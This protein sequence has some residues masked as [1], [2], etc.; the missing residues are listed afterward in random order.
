MVHWTQKYN[1]GV[2]KDYPIGLHCYDHRRQSGS[3]SVGVL[4]PVAE[5]FDSSRKNSDFPKN[6]PIFQAKYFDD[7]FFSSQLKKCLFS[8]NIHIFTFYA[9]IL[10]K[11]FSVSYKKD[12]Q[13]D[14]F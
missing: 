12:E 7:L 4:N 10:S 9:Y 5:I 6:S 14:A 8:Q 13:N 3:K 2:H 11:F 1:Q